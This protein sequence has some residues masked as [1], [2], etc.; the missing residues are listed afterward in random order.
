MTMAFLDVTADLERALDV[1]VVNPARGALHT[2]ELLARTGLRQSSRAYPTPA[3]LS[4]GRARR[5]EDLLV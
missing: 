1:P 4:S 2:A 5:L 3:K